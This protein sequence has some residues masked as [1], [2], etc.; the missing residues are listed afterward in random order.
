MG[1]QG[2]INEKQGKPMKN[3]ENQGK[4]RTTK[5]NQGKPMQKK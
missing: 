2:E 1:N 5:E 3:K 4:T